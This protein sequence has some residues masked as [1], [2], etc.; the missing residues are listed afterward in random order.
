VLRKINR[1]NKISGLLSFWYGECARVGKMFADRHKIRHHCWIMGQDARAENNY[2]RKLKIPAGHLITLSDFLQDEFQKNH[3]LRPSQV[4]PAG[5]DQREFSSDESVRDIEILGAGSLIPLK[6]FHV[7]IE[8]VATL[9]RKFPE[10]R[11]MIIGEGPERS[12]LKEKIEA[13]TLSRNITLPGELA[14]PEVLQLM[15]RS[16]I[17]LHPSNYEG[18]SGVCLEAIYAGA[19]V[20]SFTKPMRSAIEGWQVAGSVSEMIEMTESTLGSEYGPH[21]GSRQFSMQT[22]V[23]KLIELY[24]IV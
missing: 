14:H 21:A 2:P 17:F 18:F 3:G 1:E 13:L 6:Q 24:K 23:R 4:I 7:F 8:I 12:R 9:K 20:I 15:K 16:R 5:I 19:H 22:T 11:A 10:I